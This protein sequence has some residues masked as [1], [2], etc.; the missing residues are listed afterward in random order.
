MRRFLAGFVLFGLLVLPA[1]SGGGKQ[2]VLPLP[3][4]PGAAP[5]GTATT[6]APRPTLD[7]N[8][9]YVATAQVPA[10]AVYDEPDQ[11]EPSSTIRNPNPAYG[12]PRVFLVQEEK[13]DWIKVLLPTRPNGS[14]G[15]VRKSDV[16]IEHHDYRMMIELGA[17]RMVVYKGK[18]V[19]FEGPVGLGASST[20]TPTGLFYTTELLIPPPD[21]PFYGAYAYGISGH[22]EVLNDFL[23]G[24]GQVGIHGTND[25]SSVGRNVSNGCVRMTNENI[26]KLAET[27]PIGVPVEIKA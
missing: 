19:F 9:A 5:D 27:L 16:M 20:P 2:G 18:D 24:D 13:G 6:E 12:T 3:T 4:T 11:P 22:S 15:W 21:Q 23:G 8:L 17:H 10:V 25:P 1:C 26:I 14:A 7:P